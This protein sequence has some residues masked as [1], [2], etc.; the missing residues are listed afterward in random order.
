MFLWH[1]ALDPALDICEPLHLEEFLGRGAL[2]APGASLVAGVCCDRQVRLRLP[3]DRY[4]SL[5]GVP[6][7]PGLLRDLLIVV[8]CS[9]PVL[10][11]DDAFDGR[12]GSV[13]LAEGAV[14]LAHKHG[15][16]PRQA[17]H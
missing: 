3:Y 11:A 10:S 15:T 14:R 13:G 17:V 8:L 1:V 2:R 16:H 4:G 5:V 7:R 12:L 6:G 9:G